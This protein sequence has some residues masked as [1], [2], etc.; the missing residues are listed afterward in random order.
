[1]SNVGHVKAA[2]RE[3]I[4]NPSRGRKKNGQVTSRSES[5]LTGAYK[6][7]GY[8]KWYSRITVKGKTIRLKNSEG[9]TYFHSAQ[10]AHEAY[11]AAALDAGI[12]TSL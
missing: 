6:C 5:G 12:I 8:G 7:C 2:Y 11:L 1:M 3:A 4:T 9:K 10:E